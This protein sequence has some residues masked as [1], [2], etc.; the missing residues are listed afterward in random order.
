[1]SFN[2]IFYISSVIY[3]ENKINNNKVK[4]NNNKIESSSNTNTT[5]IIHNLIRRHKKQLK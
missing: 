5:L 2:V 1:M 3:C 4:N